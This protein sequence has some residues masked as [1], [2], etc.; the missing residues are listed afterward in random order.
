[1]TEKDKNIWV[2][3]II[4]GTAAFIGVTIGLILRNHK[5]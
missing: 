4:G 3:M 2:G 5:K 1:M